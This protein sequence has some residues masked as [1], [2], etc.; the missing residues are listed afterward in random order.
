MAKI[1]EISHGASESAA[2][3]YTLDADG[4][5]LNWSDKSTTSQFIATCYK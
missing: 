1:I 5:T 2:T 4:F 3:L